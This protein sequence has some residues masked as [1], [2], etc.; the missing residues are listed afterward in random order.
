MQPNTTAKQK[1]QS[2]LKSALSKVGIFTLT[3]ALTGGVN[4]SWKASRAV[5]KFINQKSKKLKKQK[6][7]ELGVE[8]SGAPNHKTRL[9]RFFQS[10]KFRWATT[11]V[12]W[13][14]LAIHANLA[15]WTVHYPLYDATAHAIKSEYANISGEKYVAH[16]NG[17]HFNGEYFP[18]QAKWTNPRNDKQFK[19]DTGV[20]PGDKGTTTVTYYGNRPP[21]IPRIK[22]TIPKIGFLRMKQPINVDIGPLGKGWL[23]GDGRL[24]RLT[25]SGRRLS[26]AQKTAAHDTFPMGTKLRVNYN[27]GGKERSVIVTINDRG[28]GE[29][30]KPGEKLH[31]TIDLAPLSAFMLG[32]IG[33]GPRKVSYEVLEVPGK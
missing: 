3:T 14:A 19:I 27:D 7:R 29:G 11:A 32:T 4:L 6:S 23:G 30:N 16:K 31:S 28:P 26:W 33:K 15:L 22:F 1:Y 20:K 10:R 12:C 8:K 25:A 24:A 17:Y 5:R 13:T 9:N 2:P 21:L 18:K